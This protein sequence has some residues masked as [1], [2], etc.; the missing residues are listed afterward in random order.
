MPSTVSSSACPRCNRRSEQ[1]ARPSG[2]AQHA[3]STSVPPHHRPISEA[4]GSSAPDDRSPLRRLPV[5]T[6]CESAPPLPCPRSGP[7]QCSRRKARLRS[8]RHPQGAKI[9]ARNRLCAAALPRMIPVTA[10]LS[11]SGSV[12][13]SVFL[14]ARS[15]THLQ[16]LGKPAF[17]V[18]QQKKTPQEPACC[19]SLARSYFM[20]NRVQS[21]CNSEASTRNP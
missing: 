16:L 14:P 15:M 6:V 2:G 1:R 18:G 7:T 10:S 8:D 12:T 9:C 20:P 17:C 13:R 4:C 21:A 3:R 11:S 5:H 19:C